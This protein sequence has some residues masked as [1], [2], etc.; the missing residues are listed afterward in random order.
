MKTVALTSNPR[1]DENYSIARK[2][3]EYL[4][5]HFHL[6]CDEKM[7]ISEAE[8]VSVD[9]IRERADIM[10]VIGGD[11]TILRFCR[12]LCKKETPVLGINMGRLGFLAEVEV[13]DLERGMKA[14]IEGDYKI[15]RRSM[16]YGSIIRGGRPVDK[17]NALNDVVVSCS[18]FKRMVNT[19]IKIDGVL[20]GSY[21]SDGIIAATPTGSTAYSLSAGGPIVDSSL[22]VTVLTP[23]CPHTLSSRSIIVPTYKPIEIEVWSKSAKGL[24]LTVDGQEG[25]YLQNDDVVR[26]CR[27]RYKS[28]LIKIEDRNF[29]DILKNKISERTV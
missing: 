6:I 5:D 3:C 12:F 13:E 21:A 18:S 2:V 1:K 10:I 16:L 27:S 20:A 24:L 25:F 4:K 14:L 23:I 26:I 15:E 8:R 22:D 28:H 7:N 9:E 17:F 19:K 29:Y 11:G